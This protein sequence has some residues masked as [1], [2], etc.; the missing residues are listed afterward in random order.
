MG[1]TEAGFYIGVNYGINQLMPHFSEHPDGTQI[2]RCQSEYIP[3]R[4]IHFLVDNAG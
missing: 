4:D 1:L 3:A 2:E